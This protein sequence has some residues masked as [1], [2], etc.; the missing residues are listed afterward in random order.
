M[1]MFSTTFLNLQNQ[2][3]DSMKKKKLQDRYRF[4]KLKEREIKGF[5][6]LQL[7]LDIA[8]ASL[9]MLHSVNWSMVG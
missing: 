9:E 1:K 4:F 3:L 2:K 8:C 7:Y 5:R 6:I